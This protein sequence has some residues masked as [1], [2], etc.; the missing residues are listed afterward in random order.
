MITTEIIKI[1]MD[2][3]IILCVWFGDP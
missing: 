2:Y 3:I 1:S